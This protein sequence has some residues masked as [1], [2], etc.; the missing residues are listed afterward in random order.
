LKNWAQELAYNRTVVVFRFVVCQA[1]IAIGFL[2]MMLDCDLQMRLRLKEALACVSD[3]QR[4][5]ASER[6]AARL[7]NIARDLENT[8]ADL[9]P[10]PIPM[11]E[12]RTPK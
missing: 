12:S 5:V 9:T 4:N 1:V 6:I 7:R 2:G 10:D 3:V 11:Y 8:L